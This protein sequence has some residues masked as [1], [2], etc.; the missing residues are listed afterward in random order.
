MTI[1]EVIYFLNHKHGECA[2]VIQEGRELVIYTA[3]SKWRIMLDDFSRFNTYTLIHSN[4]KADVGFFHK[5]C[6]SANL[7]YL[8]YY[9]VTHDLDNIEYDW[10]EFKRLWEMYKLGR[11]LE[12]S[13][14]Q[15]A[16]LCGEDWWLTKGEE[17]ENRSNW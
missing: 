16:F 11:E 7:D 8:V 2:Y 12:E 13:C 1:N 9:A 4:H 15:F 14:S 17:Y 6:T 3:R 5:Q 10:R